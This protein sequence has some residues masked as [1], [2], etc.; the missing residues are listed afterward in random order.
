MRAKQ[1]YRDRESTEVAVLDELVNRTDDGMTVFEL[2]AA[3]EVEIDALEE[4]LADLKEDDLI[5]AEYRESQ[6]V[7]K[8]DDRVV[9]D[10]TVDDDDE[11]IADWI[12]KRIPF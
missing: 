9:P 8:P 2:R 11:S 3:V 4:A 5:T 1:E 10:E 12:R 7:I 6:T